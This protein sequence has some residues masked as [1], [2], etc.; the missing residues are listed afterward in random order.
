[1]PFQRERVC[2]LLRTGITQ[3]AGGCCVIGDRARGNGAPDTVLA[4]LLTHMPLRV[5]G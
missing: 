3:T 5:R 2:P 1:M 4:N